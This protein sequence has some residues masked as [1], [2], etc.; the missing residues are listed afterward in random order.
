MAV[1]LIARIEPRLPGRRHGAVHGGGDQGGGGGGGEG[2]GGGGGDSGR[3]RGGGRIM[4]ARHGNSRGRR[5][6]RQRG[7]SWP[8]WR[9][10]R[11][12]VSNNCVRGCVLRIHRPA[13]GG[14]STGVLG[15]AKGQQASGRCWVSSPKH[16]YS[17][18]H[19]VYPLTAQPTHTTHLTHLTIAP[20]SP[21]VLIIL[22]P[23][24]CLPRTDQESA[25]P[26]PP[27]P[28]HHHHH[29]HHHHHTQYGDRTL[30]KLR[31]PASQAEHQGTLLVHHTGPQAG[32]DAQ[33]AQQQRH[34]Q[35][36]RHHQHTGHNH[37]RAAVV[38]EEAGRGGRRRVRQDMSPDQ[39]QLRQLPRGKIHTPDVQE[40]CPNR[41]R[42]MYQPSLK[43]TLLTLR[44]RRPARWSSLPS[45][46]PPDRKSTTACDRSPT[47]RPIS[48]LFA[49]PSTAPTRSRT[50]WTR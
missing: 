24:S 3:G 6:S 2:E 32:A 41:C 12:A 7:R 8:V 13:M 31:L 47:P 10:V 25:A 35:L 50:S 27:H 16:Q 33:R 4:R 19:I 11:W 18:A 23:P 48:S 39:L 20:A 42:N 37:H 22:I 9:V 43:T 28:P 30:A 34:C 5:L 49:S 44:I 21:L 46:I 38:L 45:G 40:D 29:H 1:V 26:S 17:A 36:L 15:G 14:A